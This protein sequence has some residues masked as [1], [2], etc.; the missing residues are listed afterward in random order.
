MNPLKTTQLLAQLINKTTP[1]DT[2]IK[3]IRA[4]GGEIYPDEI[5]EAL[6]G[7]T[8]KVEAIEV[9]W[10]RINNRAIY[11]S[12]PYKVLN[13]DTQIIKVAQLLTL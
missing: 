5:H 11:T 12:N 6:D 2:I 13:N 1:S 4:G 7:L 10:K 3:I 8:Q 9:D